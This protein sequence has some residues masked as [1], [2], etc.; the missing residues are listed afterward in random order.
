MALFESAS[1]VVTPNGIKESKL[2]SIKPTDGSGDLTVT[3]AT[4]AT[5]VNSAGLIEEV[6][7]NLLT[8][9]Q[10][11]N[12]ASWVK[13]LTTITEN[14][15]VSPNGALDASTM[16]ISGS[17]SNI[18]KILTLGP[19]TYTFSFYVKKLSLSASGTMRLLGTVDGANA[20][21][22]FTPTDEW[23]RYT[24]TF[25]AS[26]SLTNV[27]LR[28]LVGTGNV[29]IW[30]AQ[31]VT[32]SVAKDYFPTT[33]RL[34]V[35]RLDYTN[36]TCPS[37]LIEPQRTNLALRSE[38]FDNAS[39]VKTNSTITA[40]SVISPDGTQD[41]DTFIANGAAGI[42]NI[43]GTISILSETPYSFSVFAKKNTNNFIQL[44][45]SNTGFGSNFWA[46]FDLNNGVLG[47]KG[48]AVTSKIENYGNGWYRCTIS[49]TSAIYVGGANNI[50]SICTSATSGRLES[51]SLSTSV[52]LWGAQ[53]EVG[54]N[55]T[56]YIPT[57]T[58]SVTRNVDVISKTGISSLIGQTEGTLYAEVNMKNWENAG[59]IFS[60]SD[61]T[62]NN[63]VSIL[64]TTSKRFIGLISNSGT[65]FANIVSGSFTD[66]SHKIALAYKQNDVVFYIDGVLIGS[67]TSVSIPTCSA[68]YLGK[69]ETSE[70][71]NVL[72]DSIKSAVLW[73]TRLTNAEL[74][75]LT[76]L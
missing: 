44:V 36:S 32:G 46:N 25:T 18:S 15:T 38:E 16:N 40:N 45:G 26:T 53:L 30:G 34:N 11:F 19:G 74:A 43:T 7:Y 50:L 59:R 56:S 65:L 33:T 48:S 4:S 21:A 6:P 29:A 10:Y 14:T 55:A 24:S 72:N 76:K 2:Y 58:A 3:R 5:R 41:A 61:E 60:I 8:Y 68:A 39:W 57:T 63:V 66:G 70:T 75:T 49:G 12:D 1:L 71:T 20:T 69:V 9:S 28:G 35:P 54:A 13:S 23:V 31:L 52:Y 42:K 47:S 64:L 51:N 67:D 17:G 37:I 62:S 22:I 27:Q 73:K